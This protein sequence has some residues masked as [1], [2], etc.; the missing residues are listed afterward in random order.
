MPP[1]N[2]EPVGIG[3]QDGD[4]V[5]SMPFKGFALNAGACAEL[6]EGELFRLYQLI[7]QLGIFDGES[8]S[9]LTGC[10]RPSLTWTTVRNIAER[11]AEG[12]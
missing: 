7:Q 4:H 1:D 8:Q 3:Q 5:F 12:G 11:K 10:Q 6:N 2:F 9:F